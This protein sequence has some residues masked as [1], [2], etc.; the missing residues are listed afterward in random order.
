MPPSDST[1]QLSVAQQFYQRVSRMATGILAQKLG[2][3][4]GK[5]AAHSVA[6]AMVSAIRTAR[7]PSAFLNATDASVADVINTV[8]ETGLHPGG[9]NPTVYLV[10]QAPRQGAPPE[11]QFRIT[12]RGL[13][14][15]GARAGIMVVTVPVGVADEV[16]VAFGEVVAHKPDPSTWPASLDD[17]AG[18]IVVVR[19]VQDGVTLGRFWTPRALIERRRK[20]SRDDSVWREWPVEM[21]QKT[22]IKWAFARGMVPLDSPEMRAALEADSR[23]DIIEGHA[24]IVQPTDRPRGLAALGLGA[25]A[26]TV[27]APDFDGDAEPVE[28]AVSLTPKQDEAKTS[29]ELYLSMNEIDHLTGGKPPHLWG[30]DELIALSRAVQAAKST[31]APVTTHTEDEL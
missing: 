28:A 6:M 23:G 7:D 5:K 10:P 8:Y 3:E 30:R 29:A 4:A 14:L 1:P 19:R 18:V 15:L 25:P 13:T 2:T 11:L 9:P 31:R 26:Q 21:A 12:H 17:L 20:K 22:A 27:P 24:E 16:D